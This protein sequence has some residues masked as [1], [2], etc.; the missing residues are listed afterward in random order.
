MFDFV[1]FDL[2]GTISKSEL[3]I[4]RC[5]QYALESIGIHESDQAVLRTFIGP[6]LSIH[7]Q[8]VYGVDEACAEKLLAKYRKRYNTI[9]IYEAEMYEGI[10]DLLK[11]CFEKG[12]KL[13][14]VSSKPKVYLDQL[15]KHFGIDAF[16]CEV[17]GPALQKKE[18]DTKEAMIATLL[19][20][21][22]KQC[23]C[24]VGDRKFDVL[25][26]KE[27]QVTSIAVTY[28]YGTKAELEAVQPDIMVDSVAELKKV[29]LGF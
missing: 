2:D 27:N 14:I 29:L 22:P 28:G 12:I 16:F 11:T 19:T 21:Y 23:C 18:T 15:L 25:G 17:L 10:F 24:M 5:V 9:G 1:L 20:Q 26:A 4:T 13:G 6:P 8:E 3:G 7:F